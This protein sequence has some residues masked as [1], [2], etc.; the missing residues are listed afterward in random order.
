[1]LT[2]LSETDSKDDI[3]QKSHRGGRRERRDLAQTSTMVPDTGS[4]AVDQA[5]KTSE[6][7]V[8]TEQKLSQR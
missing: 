4:R 6:F 8:S 2:S 5:P 3:I 7:S 1:M